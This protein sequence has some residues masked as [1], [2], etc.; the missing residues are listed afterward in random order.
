MNR[1]IGNSR[2]SNVIYAPASQSIRAVWALNVPCVVHLRNAV[3]W[4]VY[5]SPNRSR[6][7]IIHMKSKNNNAPPVGVYTHCKYVAH[8]VSTSAARTLHWIH[9][10]VLCCVCVLCILSIHTIK[11]SSASQSINQSRVNACIGYYRWFTSPSTAH[12][13][14]ANT[15]NQCQIRLNV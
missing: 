6:L 5:T 14:T 3:C 11:S 10:A 1:L 12:R 7:L 2:L 9:C 15:Y 13:T 4:N 8:P